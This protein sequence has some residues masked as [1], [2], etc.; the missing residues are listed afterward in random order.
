MTTET[1]IYKKHHSFKSFISLLDVDVLMQRQRIV[2]V[3]TVYNKS[4][5]DLKEK[6]IIDKKEFV[7]VF[8]P[9]V[10]L[11]MSGF[12]IHVT[13]DQIVESDMKVEEAFKMILSG[14]II[15]KH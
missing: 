2:N 6:E 9:M 8:V 1:K 7:N 13:K 5:A 10:P 14:G 4:V 3:C 11:P 15:S 12:L